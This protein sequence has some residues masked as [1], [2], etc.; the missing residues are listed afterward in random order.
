MV[1]S[2][3][4][5]SPAKARRPLF[6]GVDVG[7]TNI[8]IGVV[9][10]SGQSLAHTSMPTHEDLGP[11]QAVDRANQTL[12]RTVKGLGLEY[13]AIARVGLGT[14][15]TMDVARGVLL[16]PGNLP[17]WWHFPIQAALA[18]ACELPVTFANDARSSHVRRVL[19]RQRA[20]TAQHGHV[21]ARY[22][23]R[24]RHHHR[25]LAGRG[26][27]QRRLGIGTPDHRLSRRLAALLLRPSGTFGGLCQCHGRG[28][29][30]RR[31]CW[32]RAAP[33]R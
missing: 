17:H 11:Q 3:E 30:D 7:G 1:H 26:R 31:S 8:K 9:D 4:M 20:A 32:L 27:E 10:D 18:K 13:Q 29:T 33:A 15:G 22:R 25:R 23:R 12:R 2:R 5:I 14:P 6:A 21:H 24:R 28:E 19:G 16:E